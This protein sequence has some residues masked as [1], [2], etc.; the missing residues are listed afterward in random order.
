MHYYI[1]DEV[2]P[3]SAVAHKITATASAKPAGARTLG[4]SSG[5]GGKAKR[6]AAR[7]ARP[8]DAAACGP[9]G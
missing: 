7:K 4:G 1:Q 5:G 8:N 3:D 2:K 9:G 6:K